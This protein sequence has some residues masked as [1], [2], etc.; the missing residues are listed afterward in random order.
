MQKIKS[1]VSGGDKTRITQLPRGNRL[2]GFEIVNMLDDKSLIHIVQ[3]DKY[4]GVQML[5][6]L[7]RAI[8]ATTSER[9]AALHE[10]FAYPRAVMRKENLQVALK[11]WQEDLACGWCGLIERDSTRIIEIFDGP[12]SRATELSRFGRLGES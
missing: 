8:S 5:N 9:T 3:C 11:Q 6:T 7:S 12:D 2:L 1:Y 10:R 4:N